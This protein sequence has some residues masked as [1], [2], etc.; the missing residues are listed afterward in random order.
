MA[1]S[2]QES[3]PP[4]PL[5]FAAGESELE[6]AL[7]EGVTDRVR[8]LP[9]TGANFLRAVWLYLAGG[10][11]LILLCSLAWL[12]L[13]FLVIYLGL[14]SLLWKVWRRRQGLKR[15]PAESSSL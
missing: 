1:K 2:I 4:A 5:D 3:R 12:H 14:G 8:R 11:C 10:V 13:A 15:A 7:R 6:R 9:R